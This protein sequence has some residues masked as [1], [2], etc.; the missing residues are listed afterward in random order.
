MAG[1]TELLNE[2]VDCPDCGQNFKPSDRTETQPSFADEKTICPK[3]FRTATIEGELAHCSYC[4][5]HFKPANI[6]TA[7]SLPRQ[8]DK[9]VDRE[10][11][12]RERD[13]SKLRKKIKSRAENLAWFSV[14]LFVGMILCLLI[15]FLTAMSD[16]G[17]PL[18]SLILAGS[19]ASLGFWIYALAQLVHI[20][21]NTEK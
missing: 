7:N 17:F 10:A 19:F 13:F 15:A 11:I 8:V 14:W 6:S 12:M 9:S 5:Y 1:P 2:F 20:R 18:V 4:E 16:G 3:C 21:A